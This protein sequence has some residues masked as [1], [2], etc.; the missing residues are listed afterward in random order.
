MLLIFFNE[1]NASTILM[2]KFKLN[3][4][5]ENILIRLQSNIIGHLICIVLNKLSVGNCNKDE[6][7]TWFV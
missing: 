7:F 4:F 1:R 2:S 6:T 5:N 3:P